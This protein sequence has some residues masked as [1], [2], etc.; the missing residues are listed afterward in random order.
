MYSG[1]RV[2]VLLLQPLL[3]RAKGAAGRFEVLIGQYVRLALHTI[4]LGSVFLHHLW[5]Y[6]CV[7]WHR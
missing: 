2:V 7:C 4:L 3:S 6:Q 5:Q 1:Y